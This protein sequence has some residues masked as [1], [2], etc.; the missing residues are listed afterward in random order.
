MLLHV[1]E[2]GFGPLIGKNNKKKNYLAERGMVSFEVSTL[3][4]SRDN[5]D[6]REGSLRGGT[7]VTCDD[8]D[9]VI[10]EPVEDV[11]VM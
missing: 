4:E 11:N 1:F 3:L 8:T 7:L 9:T 2:N 5:P 10:P 6:S